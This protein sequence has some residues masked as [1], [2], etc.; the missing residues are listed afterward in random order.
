MR[1][2]NKYLILGLVIVGL[3]VL[4]FHIPSVSAGTVTTSSTYT[5]S[6][7]Y[8]VTGGSCYGSGTYQNGTEVNC[9]SLTQAECSNVIG[10]LVAA[11]TGTFN[12]SSLRPTLCYFY[13]PSCTASFYCP[14][15]YSLGCSGTYYYTSGGSCSGTYNTSSCTGTFQSSTGTTSS[16]SGLSQTQCNQIGCRWT[17]SSND[18][19]YLTSQSACNSYSTCSWSS[20][21]SNAS[22]ST[23]GSNVQSCS[24]TYGC[25][26]D[27]EK[28]VADAC[29]TCSTDTDCSSGLVCRQELDSNSK[30]CV[31]SGNCAIYNSSNPSSCQTSGST[32]QCSVDNSQVLTCNTTTSNWDTKTNCSASGQTC[33]VSTSSCTTTQAPVLYWAVPGTNPPQI[34]ASL[35]GNPGDLSTAAQLLVLYAQGQTGTFYLNESGLTSNH[36]ILTIPNPVYNSA[37]NSL[38]Y[39]WSITNDSLTPVGSDHSTNP[40]QYNFYFTYNGYQSPMLNYTNNL[41]SCGNNICEPP[42]EN[43]TSCSHDCSQLEW[44]N[45]SSPYNSID[46]LSLNFSD[47]S[48]AALG[49]RAFLQGPSSSSV[50]FS[51]T[52]FPANAGGNQFISNQA[53][54]VDSDG[55]LASSISVSKDNLTSWRIAG[56]SG[57]S[58]V[59]TNP[60]G[61]VDEQF[62]IQVSADGFNK[63]MTLNINDTPSCV[64]YDNCSC[65]TVYSCSN[66][67]N[68]NSCDAD[69]CSVSKNYGPSNYC[70]WNS[71][72][73]ICQRKDAITENGVSIGTCSYSEET[74]AGTCNTTGFLT[75]S[76]NASWAWSTNNNYTS[77]QALN[78]DGTLKDGYKKIIGTNYFRYDPNNEFSKCVPGE[79][80]VPCP[81]KIQLSFFTF[82]NLLAAAILIALIYF[83]IYSG[84]AK[85]KS[86]A[87]KTTKKVVKKKSSK[88]RK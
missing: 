83:I 18:C 21:L 5:C 43:Y 6:G 63:N 7:T 3:F 66:Y 81:A 25:S 29:Q 47:F 9:A 50:K 8:T 73:S 23:F 62:K 59:S 87:K 44:T 11:Q 32:D 46:N 56:G 52:D 1:G 31:S 30:V 70:G 86:L 57:S 2:D 82:K 10:C 77:F 35:S 42:N 22:C 68:K 36:S 60:D 85:K 72:L 84:K 49:L 76:W 65:S 26:V 55:N 88:K 33:N 4:F 34:M 39:N 40:D 41:N 15:S 74:S 80:T 20:T 48:R 51:F 64:I 58:V 12:C 79:S 16:C 28:T 75:Y 14:T 27:C 53:G 13:S 24:T 17:T 45:A 38:S 54:I 69:S 71:Q 19:S 67:D 61:T 37:S 78:P